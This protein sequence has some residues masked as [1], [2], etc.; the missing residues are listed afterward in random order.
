M[1][2]LNKYHITK[3]FYSSQLIARSC[4]N[5]TDSTLAAKLLLKVS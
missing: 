5:H 2:Y 3:V 1:N 4:L